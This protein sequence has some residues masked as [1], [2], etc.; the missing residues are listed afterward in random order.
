MASG[1][2]RYRVREIG[3]PKKRTVLTTKPGEKG[4]EEEYHAARGAQ[5]K[6]G[7]THSLDWLVDQYIDHLQA[8][9]DAGISSP[10]T[11]KQRRSQ[12]RRVCAHRDPQG[13]RYGG[14]HMEAPQ[15][16]FIRVR[17]AMASTPGEADNTMKSVR[18]LYSFAVEREI[19]STNPATGISKIHKPTGGATPWTRSDL[20]RYRKAH[21]PGT[22]AY[23]T[24]SLFV[25]VGC[26]IG[27]AIWLGPDNEIDVEGSPWLGW[28]PRKAGSVYTEV[29]MMPQLVRAVEG[30]DGTYLV[31]AHGKPFRSA[32]GLRNRLKKWCVE[33]GVKDRS[34]HGIRKAF[35]ELLAESGAT[36]HGIMALMS[37]TQASTSE[38]YTKGAQRRLMAAEAM[39]AVRGLDW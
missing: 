16:A 12:L 7:I 21:P 39:R 15:G 3:N 10:L 26:R 25:F 1:N 13:Y 9:V 4:F 20:Q 36:Q 28:Q 8:R 37:H 22:M 31:T 5:P 18:A 27:D 33:A 17:D 11:L 14:N 2:Y 6:A 23:R 38:V 19:V 24:I 30:A 32:E 29:P 34:S 35:G